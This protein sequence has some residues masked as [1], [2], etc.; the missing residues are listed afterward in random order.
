MITST[1]ME[2]LKDFLEQF[3]VKRGKK[4]DP[5][6]H[7]AHTSSVHPSGTY[8][9]PVEYLES[10]ITHYSNAIRMGYVPSIAEKPGAYG[11]LRVDFDFKA[12]LDVGLTRQYDE[13]ILKKIVGY[14]Q[15]EIRSAVVSEEFTNEMLYCIV[16]E[17]ESPRSEEGK[18]KDGFHLHFPHFI[19]DGRLQDYY[20][21]DR[22]TSRMSEEKIWKDAKFSTSIGEL[23]DENMATKTWMMYGSMNAKGRH[24][25]PYLYNRHQNTSDDP[26]KKVPEDK[27][28]GHAY[29]HNCEEIPIEEVFSEEMAGRTNSIRYYLPRFMTIRGYT[30][31]HKLVDEIEGK[32]MAFGSKT[33]QRK[34]KINKKRSTEE[35][36]QDIKMIKD[37]H[38]MEMISTDRADIYDEWMDVG[39]TLFNIGQGHSETLEM[40]IEFS[41]RSSNFKPGECE[42]LWER[43]DLR[44]KTVGSLL[45]MAKND[46]P[47]FYKQWK[48]TNVRNFIYRSLIEAKPTEFD[49]AMVVVTM[50]KDRFVCADAKKDTWYE[51]RDHRWHQMDDNIALKNLL[52]DEVIEKYYEFKAELAAQ[53][54]GAD[55]SRRGK[56]EL[57]E[58]RV[59]GIISKLKTVKFHEQVIKMCKLKMHD[60]NFHKKM[61]ENRTILTCENG[62]LDLELGIFRDGRPDDYSTFSSGIHYHEYNEQD[63]DVLELEDFLCKV[64]PNKNRRQYF[65]D[66]ATSCLQGGNVNKRFIIGTG[67][68]DNSKSITFTLLEMIFGDYFGKFPREL[69]IR[70]RGSS[71][72]SARPELA[73]VRGKKIMASQEITHMDDF[74]IGVLKELTGNDSFFTRGLYE[75]GTEVRPMFTLWM[76][77][78]APPNIPG[79]DQATWSRIRVL[80]FESHF[81]KPQDLKKYP[82]P[83][84][85]EEQTKMKRYLA[86]PDF[87]SNLEFLAP[88]LLWK[89]FRHYPVYKKTGLREP[90]EV[91]MSTD[92][93]KSDNDV[94]LEFI[95]D[96]IERENDEEEAK[97]TYIRLADMYTEFKDWYRENHP[98]YARNMIGK[99]TMKNELNRRLGVIRNEKTE[100]HGFGKL[101]RWWGYRMIQE[102]DQ[103]DEVQ[104]LLGA[105]E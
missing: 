73:H 25:T 89:L 2:D 58:K 47:T 77:C 98:S 67:S 3:R 33:K 99:A 36:L 22:V 97:K 39:W 37:G 17:K 23:I 8:Y 31:A 96:R 60:G 100:F 29:D 41:Q 15:D 79:H 12:S 63:E 54:V 16:L 24:S 35:V 13:K 104:R 102:E 81:V 69:L 52:V 1:T 66:M 57:Q 51:F 91:L 7:V 84:S 86:D 92:A 64:F 43:M 19:C 59:I 65:I 87:V 74:N 34:R 26:W 68:G 76:Q 50:Y 11:P 20:F 32:L 45:M 78:N 21:R 44:D 62:V 55:E 46:N 105:S 56:L 101:S 27:Q 38:I 61:N 18:V 42:E 90:K 30:E 40:W 103:V 6:T 10:L 53:Q 75:K 88:A 5:Y 82:V 71:S 9:I 93:Y 70:S 14:Y 4:G 80:D 94:Y 95:K 28:W 83:E 48:D 49:I 72:S 85:K